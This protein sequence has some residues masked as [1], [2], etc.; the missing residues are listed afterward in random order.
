MELI[1]FSKGVGGFKKQQEVK[2]KKLVQYLK[3]TWNSWRFWDE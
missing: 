2:K 1:I 3:K